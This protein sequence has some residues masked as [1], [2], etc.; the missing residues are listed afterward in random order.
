[1][2]STSLDFSQSVGSGVMLGLLGLIVFIGV[3]FLLLTA[4][5]VWM[6]V[7]CANAPMDSGDKTAWILILLF[8]HL[9]GAALY[10]FIPRRERLGKRA[11]SPFHSSPPPMAGS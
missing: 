6:V 11:T 3:L 7:D 8:T 5:W 4:F 9:L 10:Y 1:M 2:N